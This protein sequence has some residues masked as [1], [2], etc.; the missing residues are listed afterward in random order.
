MKPKRAGGR[1]HKRDDK[2]PADNVDGKKPAGKVNKKPADNVDGK[3]PADNK[4]NSK[5]ITGNAVK[6]AKNRKVKKSSI[7]M[8]IEIYKIIDNAAKSKGKYFG[9][10]AVKMLNEPLFMHLIS[11]MDVLSTDFVN[12]EKQVKQ[13]SG[14]KSDRYVFTTF[15][16]LDSEKERLRKNSQK[17]NMPMMDYV[18]LILRQSNWTPNITL[19][20]LEEKKQDIVEMLKKR[21]RAEKAKRRAEKAKAAKAGKIA[22]AGSK[23]KAADPKRGKKAATK[24]AKPRTGKKKSTAKSDEAPKSRVKPKTKKKKTGSKKF[25][26]IN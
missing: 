12:L 16:S 18:P 6:T 3:K 8:P 7:N 9:D 5:K 22:K 15:R 1:P 21:T 26:N 17:N 4:K 24:S 19:D 23:K 20:L 25:Q 13:V 11:R 14:K 2:K 10:V